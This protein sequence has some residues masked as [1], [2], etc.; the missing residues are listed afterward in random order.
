[1]IT[2]EQA[3]AVL[4]LLKPDFDAHDFIAI[5]VAMYPREYLDM[6]LD[7]TRE[8]TAILNITQVNKGIAN[9]LKE[10]TEPLNI[11]EVG[12]TQSYNILWNESKCSTWKKN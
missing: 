1:M 5:Y 9:F 4:K 3:K 8:N 7:A 10:K 12:T 11:Q 2:I 6:V